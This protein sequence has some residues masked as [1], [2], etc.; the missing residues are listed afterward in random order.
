MRFVMVLV[1]SLGPGGCSL[2][3][4]QGAD[5]TPS[6]CTTSNVI[7]ALD[8]V[9]FVGS[10]GLAGLAFSASAGH[11]TIP[12]AV[13]FALLGAAVVTPVSAVV[14]FRRVSACRDL[15]QS[16]SA[17]SIDTRSTNWSRALGER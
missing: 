14:G 10:V 1:L 13:F 17:T 15:R 5:A 3:F 2:V 8:L 6:R 11:T 9:G 4:V 16:G 7:P 12:D